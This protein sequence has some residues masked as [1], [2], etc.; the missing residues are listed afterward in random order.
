[1]RHAATAHSLQQKNLRLP[2][3][4]PGAAERFK[5]ES[6]LSWSEIARRL[7]TYRHT[8]WRWTKSGV[9]PNAQHMMALLDLADDLGLAHLFTG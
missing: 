9:R 5:E 4:L 8:V 7:G 2:R 1:M 3:R 6:G